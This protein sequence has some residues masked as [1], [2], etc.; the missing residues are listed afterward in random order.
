M[1]HL[2]YTQTH[3]VTVTRTL[4]RARSRT[5]AR[6]VPRRCLLIVAPRGGANHGV[7]T[8]RGQQTRG[9]LRAVRAPLR[10]PTPNE[11]PH[12][13]HDQRGE[14]RERDVRGRFNERKRMRQRSR[15]PCRCEERTQTETRRL[16]KRRQSRLCSILHI[17]QTNLIHQMR[18]GGPRGHFFFLCTCE[19]CA[20][21]AEHMRAI[22]ACAGGGD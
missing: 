9:Q 22:H 7:T 16:Q 12:E 11:I 21:V 1:H 5:P 10:S 2:T 13:M 3:Y 20:S 18:K 17:G 4:A 14:K 15:A 19:T 6:L 8:E